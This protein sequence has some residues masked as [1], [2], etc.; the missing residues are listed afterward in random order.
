MF[1]LPCYH[2]DTELNEYHMD[3]LDGGGMKE[4]VG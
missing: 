2:D 1:H 3:W 4:N